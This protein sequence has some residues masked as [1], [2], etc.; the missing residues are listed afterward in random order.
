MH[1]PPF[2][3]FRLEIAFGIPVSEDAAGKTWSVEMPMGRWRFGS[4]PPGARLREE[5]CNKKRDLQA[6]RTAIS[7]ES[8][9]QYV[10]LFKIPKSLVTY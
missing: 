6:W 2:F 8:G 5:R 1:P 3:F 9:C 7:D 4:P 10:V